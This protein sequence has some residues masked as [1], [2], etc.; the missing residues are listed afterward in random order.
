MASSVEPV[1]QSVSVAHAFP[2]ANGARTVG[3]IAVFLGST[4]T[5]RASGKIG[6]TAAVP[7]AV[8]RADVEDERRPEASRPEVIEHA[9][10]ASNL[11]QVTGGVA[12]GFA[13]HTLRHPAVVC[14]GS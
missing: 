10:L 12:A 14:R 4:N 7:R 2:R 11:A 8:S 1:S 5:K 6:R 9:I 3:S 13:P